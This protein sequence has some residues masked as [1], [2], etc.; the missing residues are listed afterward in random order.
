MLFL[1]PLLQPPRPSFAR[2]RFPGWNL[3]LSC[4]CSFPVSIA[5]EPP[6]LA[7]GSAVSC[8]ASLS[9]LF[10][11][12]SI[13]GVDG[14]WYNFIWDNYERCSQ[15]ILRNVK[16]LVRCTVLFSFITTYVQVFITVPAA[17]LAGQVTAE[18]LYA[19]YALLHIQ[20]LSRSPLACWIFGP[21]VFCISQ[22]MGRKLKTARSNP[23]SY[24]TV[25]VIQWYRR[26]ST[27]AGADWTSRIPYHALVVK[28][29]NNNDYE[30]GV[31]QN[32]RLFHQKGEISTLIA[33]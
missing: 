5:L 13:Y 2:P 7:C 25:D 8:H 27:T 30:T 24:Y 32:H 14:S 17:V 28:K 6:V 20:C 16:Q 19:L 10:H 9:S 11:Q 12:H 1:Y 21:S 4:T 26:H 31:N 3:L 15:L 18:W 22:V 29:S 33:Q 23:P